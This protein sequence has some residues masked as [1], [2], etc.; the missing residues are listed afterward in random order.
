MIRRPLHALLL[1][2]LFVFPSRPVVAQNVTLD[3]GTFA[4]TM[5]DGAAGTESFTIRQAGGGVDSRVIAQARI[6]WALSSGTRDVVPLLEVRGGALFAYQVEI[7]GDKREE[8]YLRV[9]GRRFVANVRSDAGEQQREFRARP[10]S[11]LLE[12][13]VA[14]Q[15][16][17]LGRVALAA[18][19]AEVEVRPVPVLTPLSGSLRSFE[20][21]L[22]DPE[23]L[24]LGGQTV[25]AR[26]LTLVSGD[27]RHEV[28]VDAE[29]RVLRVEVPAIGY[30]AVREAPPRS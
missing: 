28:W 11:V 30:V 7:S 29:G 21:E 22:G 23:P 26:H 27:E 15:Y 10:G 1:S 13:G 17:I 18:E 3:E 14:H 25:E 20:L 24:P 19:A 9:E 4:V 8:I 5:A 6:Q 16:Y 12:E 2:G